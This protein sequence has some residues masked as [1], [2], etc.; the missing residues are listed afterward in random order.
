M[1]MFQNSRP[2]SVRRTM[3]ALGL[4]PSAIPVVQWAGLH[5][6]PLQIFNFKDFP[7]Q[8]GREQH[9]VPFSAVYLKEQ[10]NQVADYLSRKKL[11]EKSRCL[12]NNHPEMGSGAGG[13]IHLK[14]KRKSLILLFP[15]EGRRD[16][17][18][19]HFGTKLDVHQ[20]LCLPSASSP[21]SGSKEVQS[22]ERLSDPCCTT[23]AQETMVFY[24]KRSSC[25]T[26]MY[27][28]EE[29][30]LK[31]RGFS[32][33]LID[34]DSHNLLKGVEVFQQLVC[35]KLLF[36]VQSSVV[37]LEFLHCGADKGLSLSILKSQVSALLCIKKP[38][39]PTIG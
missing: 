25:I 8:L 1:K 33:S 23:L 32:N 29:Q 3:S 36:E 22:R 16:T 24:F 12:Q 39:H 13:S 37:V 5:F 21:A 6:R 18:G 28:S 11:K 31:A 14:R 34:T 4:L 2:S 9:A 35:R 19:G 10:L 7:P 27:I 17:W 30:L 20:V 15:E 38:W 26:S